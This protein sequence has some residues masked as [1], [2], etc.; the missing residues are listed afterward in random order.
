MVDVSGG[1][2]FVWGFREGR[3]EL[4]SG[5]SQPGGKAVEQSGGA[6]SDAPVP[7]GRSWKRLW[8]GWVLVLYDT[9]SF[10]GASC[11]ENIQDVC[12]KTYNTSFSNLFVFFLFVFS[13]FIIQLTKAKKAS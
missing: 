8:E 5:L 13:L 11:K 7:D 6:G 3:C 4:S 9:G 2:G 12:C 10:T 1:R